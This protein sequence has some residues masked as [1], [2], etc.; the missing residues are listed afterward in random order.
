MKSLPLVGWLVSLLIF[1][2][3]ALR[4]FLI[5]GVKLDLCKGF[6]LAKTDFP[7]KIS[8]P[9]FWVKGGLSLIFAA[10]TEYSA[11]MKQK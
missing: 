3:T 10:L 5:F 4:I 9:R 8:F 11:Q 2:K 7:E 1:S 6:T